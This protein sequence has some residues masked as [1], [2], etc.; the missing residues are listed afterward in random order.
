VSLH[1]GIQHAFTAPGN[2]TITLD[3]DSSS[4]GPWLT[5]FGNIAGGAYWRLSVVPLSSRIIRVITFGD[6]GISSLATAFGGC[7]Y[8]TDL[9]PS[10]PS[11]VRDLFH[12][13]DSSN[14]NSPNISLWNTSAVASFES[15]F[16]YA[17]DFNQPLDSWDVSSA[18][19]FKAMF[20]SAVAFNQPLSSWRIPSGV[21]MERMFISAAAFNQSVDMWDMSGVSS[22]DRMFEV[23]LSFNQPLNSW[24]TS[25]LTSLWNLFW[26]APSFNQP[27][28]RW[29]TSRCI[30]I[31][32]QNSPSSM[33]L[34][35]VLAGLPTS[36]VCFITHLL[37]IKT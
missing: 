7:Q 20:H 31:A 33:F 2:Y 28:D 6:L 37:S 19:T 5:G 11:T 15:T 30:K 21:S 35:F 32:F 17:A 18:T 14:A 8:L 36:P 27:L 23:A 12:T 29:D 3:R 24:N 9:P 4:E 25:G 26:Q 1:P 22:I 13:F 10:L 34:P 16:F